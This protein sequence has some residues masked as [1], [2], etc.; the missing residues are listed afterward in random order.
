MIGYCYSHWPTS[1]FQVEVMGAQQNNSIQL[2]G[3]K[4]TDADRAAKN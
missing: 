4:W 3:S 1:K 2:L